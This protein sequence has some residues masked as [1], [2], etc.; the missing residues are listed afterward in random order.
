MLRCR[1]TLANRDETARNG[2]II[3]TKM[4]LRKRRADYYANPSLARNGVT[5]K[6]QNEL[7]MPALWTAAAAESAHSNG[8]GRASVDL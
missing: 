6:I 2:H 3:E 1:A 5:H 8:C 7:V 4:L